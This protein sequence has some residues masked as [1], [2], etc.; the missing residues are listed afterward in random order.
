MMRMIVSHVRQTEKILLPWKMITGVVSAT[1]PPMPKLVYKASFRIKQCEMKKNR[2]KSLLTCV[3][4]PLPWPG[5][6]L[7]ML[8]RFIAVGAVMGIFNVPF[9]NAWSY[10]VC[11]QCSPT[12]CTVVP[13]TVLWFE[14]SHWTSWT[15]SSVRPGIGLDTIR[16]HSS[17]LMDSSRMDELVVPS[18]CMIRK[19]QARC[20]VLQF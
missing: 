14:C 9:C 18:I 11:H 20:D 16:L 10:V 12:D 6:D 19:V 1:T 4:P 17:V 7:Y 5:M 3:Y 13:V 2:K 8:L 15:S